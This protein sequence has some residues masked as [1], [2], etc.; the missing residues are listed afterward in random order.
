M[1]VLYFIVALLGLFLVGTIFRD[2]RRQEM[3]A[4]MIITIL[5]LGIMFLMV[6]LLWNI[7]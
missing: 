3:L 7:T 1:H 6:F 2:E 4:K 5:G